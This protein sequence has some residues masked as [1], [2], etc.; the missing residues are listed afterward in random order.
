M[1]NATMGVTR[2]RFAKGAVLTLAGAMLTSP[3]AATAFA[4]EDPSIVGAWSPVMPGKAVAIH[5]A[6]LPSGDIAIW[7]DAGTSKSQP[8]SGNTLAHLIAMSPGQLPT[9]SVWTPI[10]NNLVDLF[11]AGQTLLPDGRVFVVGGQSGGY[12]F[13]IDTATIFDPATRA[14]INPPGNRMANPRWYPS[15]ITLP[16]GEVLALS[17]TKQGSGDANLIPEVWNTVESRWRELTG[18]KK[19]TYTYP[20]ISIDPKSGRVYM[21]G[22]Q[23]SNF[24]NTAG[25]GKVAAGPARKFALRNAG[26]FAVYGPG[27][28]L[29]VGGGDANTYRTAEFIDLLAAKPI[30]TQTGS[31]QQGRR[32]ATAT[33]LPDGTVLVTGGGENQIG[34]AGILAPDLWSPATGTWLPMAPMTNPRLYHS[35][36]LLMPDGRVMVGGGGRKTKAVDYADLEFF[37][38]PYLFKGPRPTIVGA[39]AQ[40]SYGQSFVVQTP[41]ASSIAKV[42]LIRLGALTH[43]V[44]TSQTFYSA[45]FSKGSQLI[46]V[47]APPNGNYAPPGFYMLFL[48]S[49]AGVPSVARTMQIL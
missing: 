45:S 20:W 40:V 38:P 15:V 18:A 10:P 21:A 35:I 16:N 42:R 29:A 28:I 39:P 36:A 49:E 25:L 17:G 23:G 47:T 12:N 26:T 8:E 30:W 27:Q 6:L 14:W 33:T 31:M 34:P 32:Y 3:F 13:G 11:C 41:D 1:H 43:A 24:L 4:A 5:A 9:A 22:P 37:S 2:R 7:Q 46:N 19:K 44:N 48:L